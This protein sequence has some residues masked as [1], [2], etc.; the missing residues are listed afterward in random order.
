MATEIARRA[1]LHG[2]M[3]KRVE[4]FEFREMRETGTVRLEGL[5]PNE[6][7]GGWK[8]LAG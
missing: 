1:R 2:P 5:G 3:R 6:D 7:E 4:E 8:Y